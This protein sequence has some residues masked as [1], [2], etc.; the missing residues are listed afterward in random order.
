MK[1]FGRVLMLLLPFQVMAGGFEV[2][3]SIE[4]IPT[5]TNSSL[6]ARAT[7]WSMNHPRVMTTILGALLA[8]DVWRGTR[9]FHGM[10]KNVRRMAALKEAQ[11]KLSGS[12]Q[13]E[14]KSL[15]EDLRKAN[16]STKIKLVRYLCTGMAEGAALFFIWYN[17]HQAIRECQAD[18]K[19]RTLAIQKRCASLND[20]A[21]GHAQKA[22]LQQEQRELEAKL[23]FLE[24]L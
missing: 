6:F 5:E 4:F 23:T 17:R 10:K 2:R 24:K 7:A 9:A 11:T 8:R 16:K 15:Y 14:L 1:K 3:Q 19:N 13:A 22:A 21:T 18:I 12:E 20:E